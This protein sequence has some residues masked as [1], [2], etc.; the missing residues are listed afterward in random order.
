[1]LGTGHALEDLVEI[2]VDHDLQALH[3]GQ[4]TS[5]P[6]SDVSIICGGLP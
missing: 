5:L 2:L 1:V 3:V 4:L 6:R